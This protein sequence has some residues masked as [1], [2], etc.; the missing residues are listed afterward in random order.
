MKDETK[1]S[2]IVQNARCARFLSG[3]AG[4]KRC[5]S[6]CALQ[7][8]AV[9]NSPPPTQER[10]GPENAHS[11]VA[12]LLQQRREKRLVGGRPDVQVPVGVDTVD[13]AAVNSL[14]SIPVEPAMGQSRSQSATVA[15]MGTEIAK[16]D[17]KFI[18]S[19]VEK[20]RNVP[21]QTSMSFDK[22]SSVQ[23]SSSVFERLSSYAGACCHHEYST[24]RGD[25]SKYNAHLSRSNMRDW[26][27]NRT[28]PRAREKVEDRLMA[29]G[30]ATQT[31]I[32]RQ[33]SQK[34]MFELA[35]L[36]ATPQISPMSD[37]LSRNHVEAYNSLTERFEELERARIR[38][39]NA[40]VLLKTSAEFL[41]TTGRPKVPPYPLD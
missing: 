30:K 8:D 33:R 27:A 41:Q 34:Q 10:S 17:A 5:L 9:L 39:N 2:P 22:Y 26:S 15:N 1:P 31:K 14:S 19:I 12:S 28:S 21:Q 23:N 16:V 38:R 6:Q 3:P 25:P 40:N 37:L 7:S 4:E 35:H 36:R 20:G 29:S 11:I 24:Q 13:A 18:P 32:A